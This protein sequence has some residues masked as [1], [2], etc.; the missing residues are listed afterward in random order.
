[1]RSQ[2]C[3][4]NLPKARGCWSETLGCFGSTSKFCEGQKST[5]P[6]LAPTKKGKIKIW[7]NS[8]TQKTK[9]LHQ[10]LIW[11]QHCPHTEYQPV[12]QHGLPSYHQPCGS[13]I[14]GNIDH[15]RTWE[16]HDW[17]D[18]HSL[19]QS[20][21]GHKNQLAKLM[22]KAKHPVFLQLKDVLK[23]YLVKDGVWC[24]K[25]QIKVPKND[26]IKECIL[27]AN[28]KANWQVTQ[29]DI[30]Q[31]NWC[32]VAS[33]VCQW[34]HMWEYILMDAI[35]ANKSS[36]LVHLGHYQYQQDRGQKLSMT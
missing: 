18:N 29:A 32:F 28:T 3:Q 7:K 14:P 33:I 2:C 11:G 24:N 30:I 1:M 12:I 34:P 20:P 35:H 19:Y 5:K 10:M 13:Q 21:E 36:G 6:D 26:L 9:D 27:K 17:Q 23:Q 22:L 4:S 15:R 31:F 8:K 16:E 25:N